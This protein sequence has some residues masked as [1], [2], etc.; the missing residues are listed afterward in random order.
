MTP[1]RDASNGCLDHIYG[2][3]QLEILVQFAGR[4]L[5]AKPKERL[6]NSSTTVIHAGS[7]FLYS[8]FSV[9]GLLY[10]LLLF[11]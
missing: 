11:H 9:T 8:L 6:I 5:I 10:L 2:T 3:P 4:L 7:V 1:G